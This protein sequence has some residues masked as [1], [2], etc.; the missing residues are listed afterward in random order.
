ETVPQR[1]RAGLAVQP[2]PA[3][4]L[5]D[6]YPEHLA[7]QRLAAA[8]DEHPGRLRRYR[9]QLG[10]Q[11]F[12]VRA[13]G[14][15]GRLAQRH[16]TLLTSFART[17]AEAGIEVQV[18]QLQADRLRRPAAGGVE[19]FQNGPV[20]QVEPLLRLRGGQQLFDAL[21]TEYLRNPFP[22][23]RRT[24]QLHG[25]FRGALFDAQKAVEHFQGDEVP[26]N[27]G[28]GKPLLAQKAEVLT[29]FADART[30][31][32]LRSAVAEPGAEVI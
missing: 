4:V 26:P 3:D 28:R 1:V 32:V 10:T 7:R 25:A 11:L 22:Q 6:Q 29:Q 5:L 24:E 2:R 31:I 21:G 23:G 17:L 15:H 30:E 13:D 19:R 9:R 8:A 27:A 12:Q 16:H 14:R 20:A 18:R